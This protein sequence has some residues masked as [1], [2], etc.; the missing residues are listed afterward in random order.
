MTWLYEQTVNTKLAHAALK[1]LKN[2][3]DPLA[4]PL[5]LCLSFESSRKQFVAASLLEIGLTLDMAIMATS[6]P[7]LAMVRLQ[8]WADSLRSRE[9]ET[10][11]L[12]FQLRRIAIEQPDFL[13]SIKALIVLWQ[14]S[15]QSVAHN[16]HVAWQQLW[17]MLALQLGVE[18]E[19]VTVVGQL[20]MASR[21]IDNAPDL[22]SLVTNPKSLLELRRGY[23]G[24][25][26]YWLYLMACFGL[27]QRSNISAHRDIAGSPL[28]GWYLILWLAGFAPRR[29]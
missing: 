1:S 23:K 21:Q 20:V 13:E 9:A 3:P 29:D 19:K 27:Y 12:V 28:L 26:S 2:F 15:S 16:R 7:L 11:P 14:N 8:W 18:S 6:E 4:R 17:L 10:T 25:A 5:A 24:R 22:P